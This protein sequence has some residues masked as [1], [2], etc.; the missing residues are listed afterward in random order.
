ME[1]RGGEIERKGQDESNWA[2]RQGAL[3]NALCECVFVY[4]VNQGLSQHPVS[5]VQLTFESVSA[6]P[7]KNEQGTLNCNDRSKKVRS[8]DK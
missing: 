7:C 8:E 4:C 1:T 2:V 3:Q 6:Y 5:P